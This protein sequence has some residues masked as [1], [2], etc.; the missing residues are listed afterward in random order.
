MNEEL[1]PDWLLSNLY[2]QIPEDTNEMRQAG[3][4]VSGFEL[5]PLDDYWNL[6][7]VQKAFTDEEEKPRK[8]LFE[9]YYNAQRERYKANTN[10][11]L[12][13]GNFES[14]FANKYAA[15]I[16]AVGPRLFTLKGNPDPWG[17]SYLPATGWTDKTR[18][19]REFAIETGVRLDDGSYVSPSEYDGY[20]KYAQKKDGSFDLNEEG[21][22]YLV[23]VKDGEELKSYEQIY[24]SVSDWFGYYGHDYEAEQVPG[25]FLKNILG[26]LGSSI[27]SM[28]EY[29]KMIIGDLAGDDSSAYKALNDTENWAKSLNWGRTERGQDF[30][31]FENLTDLGFQVS[32]QLAGMYGAGALTTV[33]TKSQAAGSVAGRLFMTSIAAGEISEIAREENLTHK[34]QATLLGL[35]SL[36]IY[37]LAGLSEGVIKSFN[38]PTARSA[39]R[40]MLKKDAVLLK[41]GDKNFLSRIKSGE[42]GIRSMVYEMQNAK[43]PKL[44]GVPLGSLAAGAG[45]ESLEESAE[46]ASLTGLKAAYNIYNDYVDSGQERENKFDINWVDEWKNLGQSA[47]GGAIGGTIAKKIFHNME[48]KNPKVTTDIWEMV[49]DGKEKVL[50]NNL[51]KFRKEKKLGLDWQAVDGT[52]I[53]KEDGSGKVSENEAAYNI[54]KGVI[55]YNVQIRDTLGLNELYKNNKNAARDMAHYLASSSMGKEASQ[56]ASEVV[57]IEDKITEQAKSL[58]PETIKELNTELELKRK[59][60]GDIVAGRAV[61]DYLAQGIYNFAAITVGKEDS[62]ISLDSLNGKEFVDL[63]KTV[64]PIMTLEQTRIMEEMKEIEK[65]DASAN[66]DN[67]Q[68]VSQIGK[69]RILGEAMVEFEQISQAL[70]PEINVAI[71]LAPDD[72]L[73]KDMGDNEFLTNLASITENQEY[74]EALRKKAAELAERRLKIRD[75]QEYE[76]LPFPKVPTEDDFYLNMIE[77]VPTSESKR[78]QVA[79]TTAVP[80]KELIDKELEREKQTSVGGVSLYTNSDQLRKIL[81]SIRGRLAQLKGTLAVRNIAP[82]DRVPFVRTPQ[83]PDAILENLKFYEAEVARLLGVSEDNLKSSDV[84]VKQ[85]TVKILR[86]QLDAYE[87]F[88][89]LA[90]SNPDFRSV[91]DIYSTYSAEIEKA[92]KAN[93][94]EGIVRALTQM[95]S[96]TYDKFHQQRERILALYEGAVP[97]RIDLNKH[98]A[99]TYSGVVDSYNYIRGVLASQSAQVI[100]AYEK[101]ITKAASKALPAANQDL[102]VKLAVQSMQADVYNPPFYIDSFQ[103]INLHNTVMVHSEGGAG[104]TSQIIP[105]VAG[106]IQELEPGSKVFLTS[107]SNDDGSRITNLRKAVKDYFTA[108]NGQVGINTVDANIDIFEFLDPKNVK[109]QENVNLVVFDEVTLLDYKELVTIINRLNL[110]NTDR[111]ANGKR[112]MKLLLTGDVYQNN[113]STN[114]SNPDTDIHGIGNQVAVRVATT[115][116]MSFS[117]RSLNQSLKLFNDYV[118]ASQFK[119]GYPDT[120]FIAEYSGTRGVRVYHEKGDFNKH[121]ASVAADLKGAG[122]LA[123]AVYITDRNVSVLPPEITASGIK[124]LTSEAAQGNEWDYVF[125]DPQNNNLFAEGARN[126]AVKKDFYTASTRA[127]RYFAVHMPKEQNITSRQ[128]SVYD[129]TPLS[130][131]QATKE[132]KLESLGRILDG[133]RNNTANSPITYTSGP[134]TIYKGSELTPSASQPQAEAPPAS[135]ATPQATPPRA[136]RTTKE[137]PLPKAVPPAPVSVAKQEPDEFTSFLLASSPSVIREEGKIGAYTFFTPGG[138]FDRNIELKKKAI[139]EAT[140]AYQYFITVAKI[141][142]PEYHNVLNNEKLKR[143]RKPGTYLAF[144]EAYVDGEPVIVAT[145]PDQIEGGKTL[146][147]FVRERGIVSDSQQVARFKISPRVIMNA[148]AKRPSVFRTKGEM[149]TLGEIKASSKTI[150]FGKLKIYR[151]TEETWKLGRA[152]R[153]FVP[154]SF[155]YTP[156]QIDAITSRGEE[157]PYITFVPLNYGRTTFE[158]ITTILEKYVVTEGKDRKYRFDGEAGAMYDALWGN[159][160]KDYS[161][162]RNADRF[163]TLGEAFNEIISKVEPGSDYHKFLKKYGGHGAGVTLQSDDIKSSLSKEPAFKNEGKA[164][165]FLADYLETTD[166]ARKALFVRAVNDLMQLDSYK[167]GFRFDLVVERD[168]SGEQALYTGSRQLPNNVTEDFLE[169]NV[170][171]ISPPIMKLDVKD[172]S[173]SLML[174]KPDT[175]ASASTTTDTPPINATEEEEMERFTEQSDVKSLIDFKNRFFPGEDVIHMRPTLD[176]FRRDM[177]DY[178]F[179]VKNTDSPV[180]NNINTAIATYKAELQKTYNHHQKFGYGSDNAQNLSVYKNNVILTSF[181]WLLSKYFPAV[182]RTASGDY[183]LN[184]SH[185]TDQSWIDKENYSHIHQGMTEM[186]KMLVFNTPL[187]TKQGNKLVSTGRYLAQQDIEEVINEVKRGE[188]PYTVEEFGRKLA[189]EFSNSIVANSL[190]YRYFSPTTMVVDGIPTASLYQVKSDEVRKMLDAFRSF[191]L[192]GEAYAL[193]HVNLSSGRNNLPTSVFG[194]P[195]MIR[196]H[197]YESMNAQGQ[198][199]G[200]TIIHSRDTVRVNGQTWLKSAAR[201]DKPYTN[202]EVIEAMQTIGLTFFNAETLNDLFT[203]GLSDLAVKPGPDSDQRVRNRLIDDVFF[204]ITRKFKQSAQRGQ[205][206]VDNSVITAYTNAIFKSVS[207]RDGVNNILMYQNLDGKKVYRLRNTAPIFTINDKLAR[208][209]KEPGPYG[210]STLLSEYS[211]RSPFVKEGFYGERD[212]EPFRKSARRLFPDEM[213]ELDFLWGFLDTVEKSYNRT[214]SFRTAAFPLMA[215]SDANSIIDVVVDSKHGFFDKLS[216][217][218]K[219]GFESQKEFYLNIQRQIISKWSGVI[220][221]KTLTELK[222]QL[223]AAKIPTAEIEKIPGMIVNRDYVDNNGFATIKQTLIDDSKVFNDFKTYSKL[224]NDNYKKMKASMRPKTME[225]IKDRIKDSPALAK[226]SPEQLLGFFYVNWAVISNDV[227]LLTNGPISDFK[228]KNSSQEYIEMVKRAKSEISTHSVPVLRNKTWIQSFQQFMSTGGTNMRETRPDLFYEGHKLPRQYNIAFVHDPVRTLMSLSGELKNQDVYDGATFVTPLTRIFQRYSNGHEHGIL[229][230]PAM[231]NITTYTDLKTGNKVFIKNAEFELTVEI[232]Q[233]GTPLVANIVK[234]MLNGPAWEYLMSQQ[235]APDLSNITQAHFESLADYLVETG[236]QDTVIMEVIPSTSVKTGRRATTQISDPQYIPEMIEINSKGT[237]LDASK[238]PWEGL[239]TKTP[240]QMVSSMPINWRNPEALTLMYDSLSRITESFLDSYKTHLTN[241]DPKTA[242]GRNNIESLSS[243]LRNIVRKAVES[244]EGILYVNQLV[245]SDD[246][247]LDDRQILENLIA[248]LNSEFSREAITVNFR[249]GHYV[250]HPADG[251]VEVYDTPSGVKLK[252]QL[253]DDEKA[254]LQSR[255][256][257]WVDP[258]NKQ[259]GETLSAFRERVYVE[260]ALDEGFAAT[261]FEEAVRAISPERQEEI[262][263]YFQEEANSDKWDGGEAEILLP[264]EMMEEFMLEPGKSLDSYNRAY[265]ASQLAARKKYKHLERRAEEMFTAFQER[266]HGII[267]RIPNT[268]KHSAV[269]TKVV[270]FMNSSKNAVFVPSML[271]FIQGA[272]QD[273]DKGTYL[274]YETIKGIR[275]VVDEQFKLVNAELFS[276]RKPKNPDEVRRPRP[277]LSDREYA[278]IVAYK[279]KVVDAIRNIMTDSKNLVEANIS[280]DSVMNDLKRIRDRRQAAQDYNKYD[281]TSLTRMIQVNQSGKRLVGIFANGLKAY[282]NLYAYYKI[283]GKPGPIGDLNADFNRVWITF[284]AFINAA[285]DNAKEQILGA[286][287]INDENAGMIA[288]LI[289]KGYDANQIDEFLTTNKDQLKQMSDAA[290]YDSEYRFNPGKTWGDEAE[291]TRI[292][293]A[294]QEYRITASVI[295]NRGI[296][297]RSERMYGLK[298]SIEMWVKEAMAVSATGPQVIQFDLVKFMNSDEYARQFIR[299][300][301]ETIA[302]RPDYEFN[303]LD[304]IHSVPHLKSYM[305]AFTTSFEVLEANS[306]AF[307]ITNRIADEYRFPDDPDEDSFVHKETYMSIMDFT[308]GGLID[309]YFKSQGDL[310]VT[311]DF[312][313]ATPEGRT[314]FVKWMNNE[315]IR[316]LQN[317]YPDNTLLQTIYPEPVSKRGNNSARL[318]TYEL[319]NIEEEKLLEMQSMLQELADEDKDLLIKYGMIVD[320]NRMGKGSWNQLLEPADLR[321][322]NNFLNSVNPHEIGVSVEVYRKF[323]TGQFNKGLAFNA[324]PYDFQKIEAI[325]PVEPSVIEGITFTEDSSQGYRERTIKNASA[326]MTIALAYD[327]NSAGE[328]LTKNSVISQGKAYQM[329]RIPDRASTPTPDFKPTRDAVDTVVSKLN[330][331]N[332]TS[333]NIAGNGLYTMRN[334]GYNQEEID[335]MTYNFLKAVVESPNLKTKITLVRSGGQTGFDEAGVKAAARLGIPAL[336]LAPKGWKYRDVRGTDISGEKSFKDRFRTVIEQ[337]PE[338][339]RGREVV[340]VGDNLIDILR[341]ILPSGYKMSIK[342]TNVTYET[343][344][345]IQSGKV[346]SRTTV[347]EFLK[348]IYEGRR[349]ESADLDPVDKRRIKGMLDYYEKRKNEINFTYENTRKAMKECG[350]TIKTK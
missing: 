217:I 171:Y 253:S 303:F 267:S 82:D 29:P 41:G 265:F 334:A 97:E 167:K 326:D 247:S 66:I 13:V 340:Q 295:L 139:Y 302:R 212:G 176:L 279:N 170:D 259:T 189:P 305:R 118:R 77:H 51:E 179:K 207:R 123:K 129:L 348:N 318:R 83:D 193:S 275:P 94:V 159:M 150:N 63:H 246:F 49:V 214:G 300:Y 96:E 262:Q 186:V 98:N 252:S 236:Q 6:P 313:L 142:T 344:I 181:D 215:Y 244:R 309:A 126:L 248:N 299:M 320:K 187:V 85:A 232:M 68:G 216:N 250:V 177:F 168:S 270:G 14:T 69:T 120:P 249:G 227:Q 219:R 327:E 127:K 122:E 36:A 301:D 209:R 143:P 64:M 39:F 50:Y 59:R 258:V 163:K 73:F 293:K 81:K 224:L 310:A 164:K 90:V 282:Q 278:L 24:N 46:A 269:A 53:T 312:D 182:Q 42:L 148:E 138:D 338:D 101:V 95:E 106:V 103:H 195:N 175:R 280:V 296:P 99:G 55:D 25:Y 34:E 329:I 57:E 196:Q 325:V 108:D 183:K 71:G 162:N 44:L 10:S 137:T 56:L 233:N 284:A 292:Y 8:E 180:M 288:Y 237:Q 235:V 254:T 297:P 315:G 149:K 266:L 308:Y 341:D 273:I 264:A 93:D 105:L 48:L 343:S 331:V 3:D 158:G 135:P 60:L 263:A 191:F 276:S 20:A 231:K 225:L 169:A 147:D 289:A 117:F 178:L 324:I 21:K 11:E 133:I 157:S 1:K 52:L 332:A 172:V 328:K 197:G 211:I 257:K 271:L 124:V 31:S 166:P 115:P 290:Y 38:L 116:E 58:D 88:A 319:N 61:D 294:A 114:K 75:L 43:T 241:Y 205:E 70:I 222:A 155:Y 230:P 223:D 314:G 272:D 78:M 226:Y 131:E 72:N 188:I 22:P 19:W 228:G 220:Q 165:Y 173:E 76:A 110:I 132:K 7:D 33:L 350:I 346:K 345:E 347:Y 286:M 160:A 17:R 4:Y 201:K 111:K 221:A 9:Q 79:S 100:T 190:Y 145:L 119:S 210:K 89:E 204:D 245:Q 47:I 234:N 208:L 107:K 5:R 330:T 128:G 240:T 339:V 192:S 243:R 92:S 153:A 16:N 238:D 335:K 15:K 323:S 321:D 102:I 311:R 199:L 136:K 333:V 242:V 12:L 152:G 229:T 298:N 154:V 134:Y 200:D 291:L 281:Y 336:V 121:V 322:F 256:L 140:D 32:A 91:K 337:R 28:V 112:L 317:N 23:P 239:W 185:F 67:Y 113:I 27:D 184:S 45:A 251:L 74:P 87:Q 104:K 26:F 260:A 161:D 268:G 144:I 40:D 174:A 274:T 130:P 202:E 65:L 151:S 146:D 342:D 156:E 30:L 125:F 307:A 287:E 109:L 316:M 2:N 261:T 86:S 255:P 206:Q 218:A 277:D 213:L 349:P 84:R 37:G 198:L 18:G 54:I 62:D 306:K 194:T 80:I 304:M 141:G 203:N 285:T 283:T 35:Y